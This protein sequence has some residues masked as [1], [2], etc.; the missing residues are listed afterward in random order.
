[1]KVF[2]YPYVDIDDV[3][4]DLN[5]GRDVLIYDH[6]GGFNS[7]GHNH[8]LVR[9]NE[10]LQGQIRKIWHV[11]IL[12]ARTQSNYPNLDIG[13]DFRLQHKA[14]WK[15]FE[16]YRIHPTH[17]YKKFICSFNGSAHVSRKLL[18]AILH[19][20]TWFDPM[21]CSKNFRFSVDEL[22]GHLS[23][24]LDWGRQKFYR[25]FFVHE[26]HKDFFNTIQSFGHVRYDHANNIY[27]LEKKL[28]TSFVHVVSET[29]ATS[30]RPFVTEKF[31]YSVVTRGLFLAFGQPGWHTHLERYYGFKKY[32]KLFDYKFDDIQNPVE[33]LLELMCMIAKFSALSADDWQ[34]LYQ[35][36]TDTIEYNYDHYFSQ[37]YLKQLEQFY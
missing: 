30:Y 37:K 1:M 22:D 9:L 24:Y 4:E 31:L 2:K 32:T 36:E 7:Q 10:A 5:H 27:N 15:P 3:I 29:L 23:D 33:R 34:D 20:M 13:F 18:V 19:R 21:T 8:I 25:H 17:E 11:Q 14:L 28:T 6:I 12:D 35:M 16:S 26:N